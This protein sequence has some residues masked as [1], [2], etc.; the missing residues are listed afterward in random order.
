[1]PVLYALEK[2]R[3]A[4]PPLA[5]VFSVLT[6]LGDEVGFLVIGLFVLW[7]VSKREGYYLLSV[8]FLGTIANQVLKLVFRIPRPWVRDPAFT[9]WEGAREGASGYSFPSGHTQNAAGTFGALALWNR[10]RGRGKVVI[11]L[12]VSLVAVVAFSRLLLGVH[13]PLDV[14]VSLLLGAV[15]VFSLY[16]LF[17]RER[18]PHFLPLFV[19]GMLLISLAFLLFVE[20]FPFPAELDAENYASA[21]KNAWTLLGAV[22]GV[23]L[24]TVVEPRF[25][26]YEVKATPLGQVLKLLLGLAAVLLFKEGLKPLLTLLFGGNPAAH[27]LR[28][29]ITVAVAGCVW[30]LTFRFWSRVGSRRTGTGQDS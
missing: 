11:P 27:A 29:F 1:M 28:Y 2:L 8:G 6:Y 14:S 25:I 19:G 13:T 10:R 5:A 9:I 15:L 4:C 22:A 3:L 18:H 20:C 23:L 24:T 17:V 7:C 21:R 12:F 26:R 16:P 30:P